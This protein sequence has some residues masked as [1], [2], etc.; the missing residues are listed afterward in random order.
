[1]GGRVLAARVDRAVHPHTATFRFYAE[2]GDFLPV[3]RRQRAFDHAFSGT[4]SVKD[5]IE[6]LGVPHV[7]VDLVV[8]DGRSVGFEHLLR[9]GER[10]AV[11]PVF[12]GIDIAPALHLRPAPLRET[13]FVLDGHLGK[14]ARLLRLLGFDAVC[15]PSVDD[16]AIVRFALVERRVILTR[17]RALL[18][19]GEVT[20]GLWIRSTEAE[21]QARQVLDR[22]DLRARAQPLSRCTTCNGEIED[23]AKH[24]VAEELPPH[25]RAT[26]ERFRRCDRC[27]QVYWEGTHFDRLRARVAQLLADR[28][29]ERE[30]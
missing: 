10:V 4:P 12:E 8:V 15:D 16:A 17:D 5:S 21:A 6:A 30:S 26:R 1:M 22:L 19:R 9:G 29:P 24:A 13:R 2:L 3:A 25:V 7:E 27:G 23:V 28:P 11:Y 14:L 20:H 18:K